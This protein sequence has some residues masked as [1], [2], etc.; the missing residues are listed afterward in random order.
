[1][2]KCKVFK[3][4]K[5]LIVSVL[6]FA[7]FGGYLFYSKGYFPKKPDFPTDL[8]NFLD[9]GGFVG[10]SELGVPFL[11]SIEYLRKGN[12]PGSDLIIEETLTPGSNYKRYIASYRS[13]GLKIYGLLTVPEEEEP[14]EGFP[15]II[16]N[17]GYIPPAQYRTTEK[18]VSYV[19]GFA[20]NGYVVFKP[21]FRGHGESEGEPTGAYGSNAYTVDALNAVSSVKKYPSVNP[22]KIGM[23][24]HSMGG[25]IT[26]RS[27]VVS[28]DIKAGVIWAGVVGSYPEMIS[29]WRRRAS[30]PPP[31]IPSSARR[32]RD[33]LQA[34]FGTP[35]ENP[36]FWNSISATSYLA[37]ISGPLSIHHGTLDA[38]VPSEF[39]ENLKGLMDKAGKEAELFLYEGDDHNLSDSFSTAMRRSVEFFDRHLK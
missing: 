37:D 39:S 20:R 11:L 32:W 17:H 7:L 4:K 38:S 13:E 6:L 14:P 27:M 33:E 22:E 28:D 31:G 10:S 35:E 26:L 36:D 24:G 23:W 15:A 25:F 18:Y 1:V 29:S 2:L 9:E 8:N 16:F 34:A 30:T 3:K 5:I 21:D 19:D 12:Y